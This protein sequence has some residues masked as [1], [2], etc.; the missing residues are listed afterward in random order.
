MRKSGH[1]ELASCVD[2][3]APWRSAAWLFGLVSLV[4]GCATTPETCTFEAELHA[5]LAP[6]TYGNCGDVEYEQ[7][8]NPPPDPAPFRA[9]HDCLLSAVAA[10]QPFV[11]IHGYSI[12]DGGTE[13][14]FE[15]TIIAGTYRLF[16]VVFSRA[17]VNGEH[18][19]ATISAC[20][21]LVDQ[22]TSCPNMLEDLCLTCA[23]PAIV[24]TCMKSS[25]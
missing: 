24:S 4:T 12:I 13:T 17:A 11:G 25:P 18:K 6:G 21:A 10:Q 8:V 2:A 15:G 3:H 20:T 23:E 22:G 16:Q 14:A 19:S 9:M 1:R 7:F 5:Q